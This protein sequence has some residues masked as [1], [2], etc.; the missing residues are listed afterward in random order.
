MLQ[1]IYETESCFPADG[2]GGREQ[3]VELLAQPHAANVPSTGLCLDRRT[4]LWRACYSTRGCPAGFDL[5]PRVQ[6][7]SSDS[8]GIFLLSVVCAA[9]S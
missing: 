1:T 5:C 2:A 3:P 6:G 7:S 9:F 8:P 4:R